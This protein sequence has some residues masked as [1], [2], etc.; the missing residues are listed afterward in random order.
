[1]ITG[2]SSGIGRA[3]ALA[4]AREGANLVLAARRE[5]VLAELADAC[6]ALGGYALAVRTDVTDSASVAHLAQSAAAHFDGIDVWVNNAGVGAVG[7][8]TD[9]P[10]RTHARVIETN[11]IAYLHGAHA[12]LPYFKRQRR[13]VLINT[14]SLGGWVASPYAVAYSASKFGLRGFSEALRAELNSWRDIHV[15][16]VFPAFTD[17][18][19]F[20]HGANYFGREIKPMPPVYPAEDVARAIV[21]LAKRPRA[22]VT[23]GFAA[24]LARIGHALFG[25]RTSRLM[26]RYIRRYM[27]QARPAPIGDGSLFESRSTDTQVSGG[28]R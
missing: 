28:W 15:C 17:T 16:D 5:A 3:T 21:S 27:E 13:G 10:I 26:G 14:V 22:A 11:L 8:F 12:V 20:Q 6:D 25:D 7:E 24:H 9:V 23:V 2:A 18:P 4:F 1:V 19:G